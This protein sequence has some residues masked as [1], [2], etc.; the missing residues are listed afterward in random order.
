MRFI[1]HRAPHTLSNLAVNV[2]QVVLCA[3][4][5]AW[6]FAAAAQDKPAAALPTVTIAA[7][8]NLGDRKSVV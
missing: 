4:L 7:K 8:A 2:S 5:A 1:G 6:C 3:S